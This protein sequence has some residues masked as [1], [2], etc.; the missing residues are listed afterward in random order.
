GF[1]VFG[2]LSPHP[3]LI[4]AIDQTAATLDI[5][6]AALAGMRRGQDVPHGM[7]EFLGDLYSA[8]AKVDFSVLYPVGRLVD[9]PLPTWAHRNL[10][11]IPDGAENQ[12]RGTHLVAAHPL[13][14]SHVRL[15]EEPERHAW[16]A[17][18]GTGAHPWLVDHQ[19]N[20]VA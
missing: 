3:L 19:I 13:L 10:V 8:G 17:E 20:N 11:L 16:A 12:T 15:L 9:A 5:S 14:G 18:V 6:V 4:R 2:E 7:G 1:R